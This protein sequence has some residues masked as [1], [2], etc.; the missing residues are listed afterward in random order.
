MMGTLGFRLFGFPVRIHPGF[1]LVCAFLMLVLQGHSWSARVLLVIVLFMAVLLHEFGHAFAARACGQEPVIVIH[2]FGGVTSWLSLRPLTKLRAIGI[3]LAGSLV[4]ALF[5]GLVFGLLLKLPPAVLARGAGM[6]L[7]EFLASLVWANG[8][9]TVLNLLPILPF[10]GGQV[11][12]LA[13]GPRRQ[14]LTAIISTLS[15]IG[16][17]VLLGWKGMPVAAAVFIATG[18]VRLWETWRKPEPV[19]VIS[20][21]QARVVL[22]EGQRNLTEGDPARA[23]RLLLALEPLLADPAMLR[24]LH[25]ILAWAAL[26]QQDPL[27]ARRSLKALMPGPIDPLLQASLLEAEGDLERAVT[28]LRQARE[29]GDPRPQLGASLVRVLLGIGRYGEAANLTTEL[30]ADVPDDQ[31]RRVAAESDTGG[32]LLPAAQLY[33]A[34]FQRSQLASDALLA[35]DCYL[36]AGDAGAAQAC[37]ER[38]K[39]A[40]L[41]ETDLA[42]D[43]RF[44]PLLRQSQ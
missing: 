20:P 31:A 2:V 8:A 44:A 11:L 38:G 36:R 37:L 32:R 13:L 18:L 16:L 22:S 35:A 28:C 42:Q 9:W 24:E 4:G 29:H 26:A 43:P 23:Q 39:A 14:R 25:E 3:A 40:G 27:S 33:E 30:L 5:A 1:W 6:T 15:G 19:S 12:S 34:L 21:E 10:D 41:S 17:G 7:R